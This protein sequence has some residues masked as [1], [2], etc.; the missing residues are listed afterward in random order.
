MCVTAYC[1]LNEQ[2]GDTHPNSFYRNLLFTSG[3]LLFDDLITSSLIRIHAPYPTANTV[4]LP[5][6]TFYSAQKLIPQRPWGFSH[7]TKCEKMCT[8]SLFS[9]TF[10]F[11]PSVLCIKNCSLLF[12]LWSMVFAT[13]EC[14]STK[15]KKTF[16]HHGWHGH[17]FQCQLCYKKAIMDISVC[18]AVYHYFFL[19]YL[20]IFTFFKLFTDVFLFTFLPSLLLL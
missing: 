2:L 14:S 17:Q 12:C 9:E 13:S 16:V 4:M 1:S 10:S 5:W 20:F 7:F 8:T 15:T 3:A 19:M 18:L 6:V 11:S